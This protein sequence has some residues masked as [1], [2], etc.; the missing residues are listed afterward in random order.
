MNDSKIGDIF[1]VQAVYT[2][3]HI[4]NK[5]FLRSKSDKRPYGVWKGIPTNVKHFK[6]FER[7]WYIKRDDKKIGNFFS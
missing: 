2:G 3:V 4:L 1:W 5:E 7:K 6:L